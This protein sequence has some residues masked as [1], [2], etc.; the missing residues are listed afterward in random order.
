MFIFGFI[1]GAVIA[2]LV[3]IVFGRKNKKKIEMARSQIEKLYN[4]ASRE[5]AKLLDELEEKLKL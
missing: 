1:V 2:S 5:T 4:G 3:F